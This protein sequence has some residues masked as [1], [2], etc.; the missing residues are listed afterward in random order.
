MQLSRGWLQ[1]AAALVLFLG[2]T[3]FGVGLDGTPSTAGAM[4]S[5]PAE[6]AS[7]ASLDEAASAV[8]MAE[9][10]WMSALREFRRMSVEQNQ[11]PVTRDPATRYAAI[12]TLLA[13]S[14]AA[15]REAP[16]DPFFNSILVSALEEREATLRQISQDN[17]Y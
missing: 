4:A 13:A 7:F 5:G 17:W 11:R 14:Q 15:I 1:A 2:G 9:Q 16:A 8:E 12:E 6:S 3:A 10:Q